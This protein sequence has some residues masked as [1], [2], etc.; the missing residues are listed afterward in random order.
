MGEKEAGTVGGAYAVHGTTAL[1]LFGELDSIFG[2][3]KTAN[4]TLTA[5]GGLQTL[6]KKL[7]LKQRNLI[8]L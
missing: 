4:W 1:Q 8:G 7:D 5:S 2:F 6:V 3:K